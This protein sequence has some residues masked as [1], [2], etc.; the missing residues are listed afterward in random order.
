MGAGRGGR[1]GLSGQLRRCIFSFLFVYK[2]YQSRIS[3][4]H[5]SFPLVYVLKKNNIREQAAVEGNAAFV[6]ASPDSDDGASFLFFSYTSSTRIRP[7]RISHIFASRIRSK[8]AQYTRAGRGGRQ[9]GVCDGL[10]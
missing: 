1:R 7:S 8:N 9:R 10:S 2:Q 6:M 4:L 3:A 5:M